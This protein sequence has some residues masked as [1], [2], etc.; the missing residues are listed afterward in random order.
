MAEFHHIE[1]ECPFIDF[2]D[3]L[4]R[5]EALVCDVTDRFLEKGK[6]LVEILNPGLKPLKRPF[7]RMQ[8]TDALAFCRENEIYKDEETKEHFAFGDDIP[9]AP[10]RKMT[11][12]IGE[13]ILLCRFPASLKSFYM[14]KCPED[15]TLTESVDL[16]MPGVGEIVGGSMRIDDEVELLEAYKRENMDPS[17]YYWFTEQRKYGTCPHGGYGLGLERFICFLLNI[18]HIRDVCLYPRYKGRIEP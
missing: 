13:P 5:I 9:E 16:L 12:M 3:L 11:D 15:R 1:A 6:H 8:Y 4:T 17:R 14:R 7:K 2:D 18:S 10:E